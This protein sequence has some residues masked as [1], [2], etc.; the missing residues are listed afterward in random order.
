MEKKE[1]L[2]KLE[3]I[4]YLENGKVIFKNLSLQINELEIHALTSTSPHS[5]EI[6]SCLLTGK[7]SYKNYAGITYWQNKPVNINS[8]RETLEM[9]IIKTQDPPLLIPNM[10]LKE[11]LFLGVKEKNNDAFIDYD[12]EENST[13]EW[14][15][16]FNLP[17][18][19]NTLIK[20]IESSFYP[21]LEIIRVLNHRNKLLILNQITI[22]RLS[23]SLKEILKDL[24]FRMVRNKLS[25]LYLCESPS[26][27][28]EHLDSISSFEMGSIEKKIN[29]RENN[30]SKKKEE[31][32]L[33]KNF[34]LPHIEVQEEETFPKLFIIRNWEG[35]QKNKIY[36]QRI[37]FSC[38]ESSLSAIGGLSLQNQDDLLCILEGT[39]SPR[40]PYNFLW[41]DEPINFKSPII[42]IENRLSVIR[43]TNSLIPEF[44]VYDNILLRAQNS[45]LMPPS[46]DNEFQ[47]RWIKKLKFFNLNLKSFF[48]DRQTSTISELEKQKVLLIQSLLT[49]P[50]LIVVEN[51]LAKL[52]KEE[53][54]EYFQI[55]KK[56]QEDGVSVLITVSSLHDFSLFPGSKKWISDDISLEKI[57]IKIPQEKDIK[58]SK[59]LEDF[60]YD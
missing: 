7:I 20:D 32:F 57:L 26:F 29:L 60:T 6:I 4:S 14:I 51:P 5:L 44:K 18:T 36:S 2:L 8:F 40:N 49:V 15:Q 46:Q 16:L 39:L 54:L 53:K 27:F 28:W 13:W 9:G 48:L 30:L 38:S 45:Q 52:E 55:L 33:K 23:S 21:L 1:I 47:K 37:N 19:P 22:D 31:E 50:L 34:V 3:N 42:S 24:L 25:V 10:E 56:I 41:R 59:S 11:N 58:E 43:Q 12:E 17:F 35:N